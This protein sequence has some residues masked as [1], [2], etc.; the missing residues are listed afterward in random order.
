MTASNVGSTNNNAAPASAPLP[1][2]TGPAHSRNWLAMN[3]GNLLHS[4]PLTPQE[5]ALILDRSVGQ[6]A[7]DRVEGK[8]PKTTRV[9]KERPTT[10]DSVSKHKHRYFGPCKSGAF[11]SLRT[12]TSTCTR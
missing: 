4:W 2:S 3:L 1:N 10:L 12:L 9:R 5:V 11:L 6:L 8:P 7:D